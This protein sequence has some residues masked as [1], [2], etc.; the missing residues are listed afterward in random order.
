MAYH[1]PHSE[2]IN[3]VKSSV[4]ELENRVMPASSYRLN[5]GERQAD[6]PPVAQRVL[7]L[8][9]T[10]A[11]L[12][13]VHSQQVCITYHLLSMPT[14]FDFKRS[15]VGGD[16]GGWEALSGGVGS[17]S[18]VQLGGGVC[19]GVWVGARIREAGT[20]GTF[21]HKVSHLMS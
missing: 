2:V 1:R 20:H 6:E 8:I 3:R 19:G 12:R 18:S 10:P 4:T 9:I 21:C 5:F 13:F 11:E 15:S 7:A 17:C 16:G 14:S